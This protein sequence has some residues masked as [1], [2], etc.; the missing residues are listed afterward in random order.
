M[1]KKKVAFFVTGLESGGIENYLL[2]FLTHYK[3]EIN[4]HVYCKSGAKGVLEDKYKSIGAQIIPMK[5]GYF[6]LFQFKRIYDKFIIEKYCTVCDF[7]GN[8]AGIIMMLSYYAKINNRIAFYRG[9]TNHFRANYIRLLY[10]EWM[11]KLVEKYSSYILSNSKVALDFFY[12]NRD[13]QDSRCQVI[14]N[15][16]DSKKFLSTKDE[17][18]DELSIPKSAF[19]V[20]HVGRF[21]KEKNHDL[22][23]KVAFDLCK[24]HDD[25][26][27]LLCG[28]G[29]D[30]NL[31]NIVEQEG[32][33]SR[34]K[35]LGN[36]TDIIRIL[37][38]MNCF[39]FPSKTEGQPNALIEALITGLPF[40]ASNIEPIKESIPK[41]FHDQLVN[42][43]TIEQSCLKILEIYNK[44]K[45]IDLRNWAVDFY[46]VTNLFDQFFRKL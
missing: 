46:N 3:D 14:Y 10:N 44:D 42:I 15:G 7:T 36:R 33:S 40:V 6:N 41:A 29:V 8:F 22:I 23:I 32:L 39:Y 45:N 18:R 30:E 37:N 19:V 27:F 4:A 5:I 24:K 13:R 43:D 9:S 2:R 21:A 28:K 34:I 1:E 25:I 31:A 35:L 20:G 38:T 17:L 16:I 26:F 12:P 11:K